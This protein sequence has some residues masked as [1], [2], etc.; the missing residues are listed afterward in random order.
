MAPARAA[1][2]GGAA[3]VVESLRGKATV[4]APHQ[5]QQQAKKGMALRARSDVQTARGG[6]VSIR[7]CGGEHFSMNQNSKVTI[8]DRQSSAVK[9]GEVVATLSDSSGRVKAST[10]AVSRQGSDRARV[11]LRKSG[12]QVIATGVEGSVVV[13][14]KH[15]RVTLGVD[16]QTHVSGNH[17]PTTPVTVNAAALVS[18][19]AP[20]SWQVVATLGSDQPTRLAVDAQGNMYVTEEYA[21]HV[22]KLSPGGR[23]LAT[24]GTEGTNPGQFQRPMG[25]ALDSAGNIYVADAGRQQVVKLSPSGS[26]IAAWGGYGSEPGQFNFPAGVALDSAGNIYVVDTGNFRI[27]KLSPS[28]APLAQ[29]GSAGLSLGEFRFPMSIKLDSAGTMYVVDEG[30]ADGGDRVIKISPSGQFLAQWGSQSGSGLGQF[31]GPLDLAVD[32]HGVIYVA[33][34]GNARIQEISSA[35]GRSLGVLG[36]Y[37]S[38]PGQF[39][40][41]A[42][43]GVAV[44]SHGNLYTAEESAHRIERYALGG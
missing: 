18:W 30:D 3:G 25:I 2:G 15:A 41:G 11:D 7:L 8:T 23:V 31:S 20:L 21:G 27:Q 19:S 32:S 38:G 42:P 24:W 6:L 12:N 22:V 4:K 13:R 40:Y 14:Q 29:W 9:K 10:V 37:G 34:A 5:K 1:C 43:D 26:E 44:D 17:A 16:K 28:G 36:N 39:T 35:D 33:D